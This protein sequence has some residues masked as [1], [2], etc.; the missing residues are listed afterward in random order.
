MT[1]SPG[2]PSDPFTLSPTESAFVE[3]MGLNAEADGQARITGR[4][5]GLMT[6]ADRPLPPAR[7]A[8]LLKISRASVSTNMKVL[9]GMGI[10]ERTT[11]PGERETYFA[12][13]DQPYS[14]LIRSFAARFASYRKQI[15]AAAK[16]IDTPAAHRRLGDLATFY[17]VLERGH[18]AMLDELEDEA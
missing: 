11:R 16:A 2:P 10:I 5:W 15:A 17:E 1:T 18:E 9:E 12:I 7:I 4:I 14:T 8:E 6:V 13:A 3:R